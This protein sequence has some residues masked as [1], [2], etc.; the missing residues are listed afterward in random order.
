M[1]VYNDNIIFLI[2]VFPRA[3][4]SCKKGVIRCQ[5]IKPKKKI[6]PRKYLIL[7]RGKVIEKKKK[8]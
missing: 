6:I 3:G 4:R 8:N 7:K 2:K 5:K 1:L